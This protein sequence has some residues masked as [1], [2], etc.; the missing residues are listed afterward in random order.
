MLESGRPQIGDVIS[1]GP[2]RLFAAERLIEKAG[3]PLHLGGR[4]LDVL[5]ALIEHPGEIVSKRD[6]VARVWPDVTVD[7]GS[8]R[9]HV[10]ALRKAL[11]D[12]RSGARYVTNVPGRGYCFVAPISR[13]NT[14]NPLAIEGFVS[15]HAYKLPVRL[16]RMV[17]RD[18]T[19]DELSGQLAAQRFV[20]IV[21]PGGIGKTTVAVSVGHA[22]IA[23]FGGDIRFVDL[24]PLND[25][26]LVPSALASTLGLMVHSNDPIPSLITFLKDKR[27]LLI[28]DSCEHVIETAAALAESI[29]REAPQVYILATSREALRVEG[30][31]V[32]RLLPLDIPPEDADLKADAALAFPAVQLF[33]ERV[34][35]SGHRFEL[36]DT[37]APIVAEICRKLEGMALAIE[38]AAGRVDAYGIQGTAALLDSRFKLLWQGQRTALPRHQ[39][40][41]AMLD[42][43]HNLLSEAERVILR[44]LSVFVGIFTLD[45]AISVAAGDGIDKTQ[46]IEA[47]ASLVAKSLAATDA[48]DGTT[49][50]RLLDTTRAYVLEKLIESGEADFIARRHAMYFCEFLDRTNAEISELSNARG[51]A[52]YGSHVGNVRAA[53]EWSFSPRGDIGAGTGLV[54]AAARL[55]LEM[56]LL[57]E[58][59]IWTERAIEALDGSMRGTSREMAL[60]VSLGQSLMFTKGNSE[61][62]RI[63]FMRGLE[64][65]EQLGD[66]HHQLQLLGGL[67]LFHERIGDF[68]SA[69]TFSQRSEAVA[70][71]IAEPAGIAAANSWL[72]I[73]YHLMGNHVDAHTHLQ[74]AVAQPPVSRRV[75]TIHFGFD[76]HNRARITLARNLWLQGYPDRAVKLAHQTVEEAAALDHPVSLCIALIWAVSVFIWSGD[77]GN[78]DE[79]IE[80]FIAHAERYSLAPYLAVGL[81][82]KGELSVRRGEASTGILALRGCLDALHADRY[83]LL[84]TVFI[85]AMAEG[86]AMTGQLDQ[87]LS[88]IDGAIAQVERNGELFI[89]PELLRLKGNILAATPGS[90][91]RGA[92]QC[93]LRSLDQGRAQSALSWE[94]RTA[95]S[96]ARLWAAQDRLDD[97]RA[98]L[99]PVYGRFTEG[100]ESADLSAAKF[101]LNELSRLPPAFRTALRPR[102]RSS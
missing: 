6:L 81:G 52:L 4:A 99:A 86:L 33:V 75:N 89:M 50:Y 80:K 94:L 59:H 32:H 77:L 11:G 9:F 44:R 14:F 17:G 47:V 88:T 25:P 10:A 76:Y 87:A 61:E 37:D 56:S 85:S 83:E 26:L 46:V 70:Q 92:E 38:L 71:R 15:D 68:R 41:S 7:D 29:M 5:I 98:V 57:T 101:L 1:F 58:C 64:L 39:T 66:P 8:L 3:A 84:T 78:A 93:L 72:G 100:F 22:Q 36:S 79:S 21:G 27:M 28:L 49:R 62:V 24:G 65:A 102:N 45:A 19:V 30:E 48:S 54:A 51:F 74:A 91:P 69:L 42:W 18:E 73:S 96:L 63:A 23:A 53:L 95:T 43:S 60:Q 2:F 40:L 67:H 20:T 82:V 13:S 97:A 55:F 34:A 35:A 31:H 12:G 16:R 90:N